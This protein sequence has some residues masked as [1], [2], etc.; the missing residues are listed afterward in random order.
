MELFLLILIPL[1][2][3]VVGFL[4]KEMSNRVFKLLL[5]LSGAFVLGMCFLH[6]LPHAYQ[7]SVS[8]V[9]N[10]SI[11]L[12]VFI[13][14]GF[15]IQI[16]L[17][18]LT[19]GI[20]HGHAHHN[21]EQTKFPIGLLIGLCIH[22]FIEGMPLFAHSHEHSHLLVSV[23]V[24]KF[25]VALIL[26]L[27]FKSYG[28]GMGKSWFYLIL[29]TVMAPLGMLVSELFSSAVQNVAEVMNYI[30]A[31]VIGVLLHISTTILFEAG[32]NHKYNATKLGMIV[33]GFVLSFIV[34]V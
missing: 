9:Q 25:P 6:L 5:A 8:T 28:L 17:D 10:G 16:G 30:T 32:E 4:I 21:H 34:S 26:V 11:W 31:I 23:L 14:V 12:G 33:L 29:F 24:H 27:V 13:L 19:G 2:A 22:A 1:S 18:W 15:L 3:G 7:Q 20:E